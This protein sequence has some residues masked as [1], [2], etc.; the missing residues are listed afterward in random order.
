MPLLT[1]PRF[2]VAAALLGAAVLAAPAAHAFTI[3]NES[4]GS[5]NDQ[6]F[7]YPDRGAATASDQS[8]QGFKQ[9]DGVTTLKDGNATLEFGHHQSFDQRYNADHYFDPL[10]RPPGVR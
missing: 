5:N 3:Q 1:S 2:A 4:P 8:A 6:S 7:L 10:G 9:D